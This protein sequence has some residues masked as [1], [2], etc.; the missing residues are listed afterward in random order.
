MLGLTE[1]AAPVALG[2]SSTAE[3]D[4][5]SCECARSPANKAF[6]GWEG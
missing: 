5:A 4:M 6:E 3:G 2:A 1:M